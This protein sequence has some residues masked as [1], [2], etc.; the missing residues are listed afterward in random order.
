MS[1]KN[2]FPNQFNW[3]SVNP[4]TGFI[5]NPTFGGGSKPS[6]ILTG[7]M[8]SMNT[9]YTN[10]IERS[11]MDNHFIE[12]S[13]TGTPTGTITVLV[14]DSGLS[15][16]SLTFT[17]AFTQ[18]SGSAAYEGLSIALLAAK[19]IMLSYTNAS[20][21]GSLTAYLQSCDVN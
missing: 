7:A 1:G 16:P 20:G 11:R 18:P 13:W 6:G 3:Q 2:Q 5:P 19:Y 15:W 9:I 21:S 17:P 10:I 8:A 14:S 12:L 4:Q